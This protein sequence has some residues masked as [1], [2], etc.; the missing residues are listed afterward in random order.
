MPRYLTKSRFKLATECPSKLFYSGKDIYADR[1]K[2]NPFLEALARGGF[3]VGELAKTYFPGGVEVTPLEYGEA[4]RQTEMHLAAE[5]ATIFE[6]AVKHD[7]FFIRVDVL[8]KAGAHLELIEVKSKS[9]SIEDKFFGRDGLSTK[10]QSYLYDIAFQKYVVQ[11][12]FPNMSVSA[13]LMLADKESSCPTDGLNQKFRVRTNVGGRHFVEISEQPTVEESDLANWIL[14]KVRVDDECNRIFAGTHTKVPAEKS[15]AELADLFADHYVRDLQIPGPVSKLCGTCEFRATPEEE[16]EG[17]LDGYKQCWTAT[18]GWTAPDFES[19]TVLDIWDNKVKD[20]MIAAGKIKFSDLHVTD[21]GPEETHGKPGLS[22]KQRQ[23]L[24]VEKGLKNDG[25]CFIDADGLSAE[26]ATWKFPLH[27][28]DFEIATPA[29]PFKRGRRPYE[30]I[31]FQF[32]HHVIEENGDVRHAGQHLDDRINTFPNYDFVR[33]LRDELGESEGT[34]FQ[35]S[36]FENTTLNMI[37]RQL[38]DDAGDIAD[39]EDLCAFIKTITKS[40]RDSSEKWEGIRT[41]VDMRELVLR[42]YYDPYTNGSNSIKL[43]LPAILNSSDYLKDRYSKSVYG[44]EIPSLNFP[45]GKVWVEFENGKVKDPYELLPK[46][47]GSE[48]IDRL[49][50]EDE[51]KD[52]GAAMMAY[53]RLQFEDMSEDEREAIKNALLRYCELDTL[54]MVMLYEGWRE[55]IR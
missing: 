55:T 37:Y 26:M 20:K 5:N 27:F 13:Y 52:G 2:D 51:L 36:T 50:E 17:K 10:W 4:L 3:Q 23:W 16:A 11:L 1:K 38:C 29:I 47:F 22:R 46:M 30:R 8:V 49:S 28:I 19:P 43:V 14:R 39:R 25:Q 7:N 44:T 24:Q 32:S 18:L 42:Y 9:Y 53:G 41:M 35:Y 45:D 15:F 6:A 33:R 21:I 54:A 12:A 48:F 31:A 40:P 34:I